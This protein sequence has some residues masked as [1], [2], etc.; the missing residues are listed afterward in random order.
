MEEGRAWK[1]LV[2]EE[3]DKQEEGGE[4]REGKREG[5]KKGGERNR[6]GGEG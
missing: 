1:R 3:R 4:G 5:E 6:N 2:G